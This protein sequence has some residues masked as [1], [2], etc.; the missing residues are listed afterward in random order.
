MIWYF[1]AVWMIFGLGFACAFTEGD[2]LYSTLTRWGKIGGFL[3]VWALGVVLALARVGRYV[4]NRARARASQGDL[5]RPARPQ[6]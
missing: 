6:R 1:V 2:A 3:L 4:M 5:F